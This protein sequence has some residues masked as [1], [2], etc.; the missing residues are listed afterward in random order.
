MT[1]ETAYMRNMISRSGEF[2]RIDRLPRKKGHPENWGPEKSVE[3]WNSKLRRQG[4]PASETL[5]GFQAQALQEFS[6]CKGLFASMA[7]GSGKGLLSLLLPSVFPQVENP[8]VLVPAKL[9]RQT[10]DEVIPRFKDVYKIRGDITVLSY[11]QISTAKNKDLLKTLRPGLVV[12]DECHLLKNFSAARTKR[13]FSYFD[14]NP[15]AMFVGLSGTI[16]RKSI[17]DYWRLIHAALKNG[18][19]PLPRGYPETQKWAKAL[20]EG[21][22]ERG[23]VHPGV[24]LDW[25]KENK[26]ADSPVNLARRAYGERLRDTFGVVAT[27]EGAIGTSLNIFELE[28]DNYSAAMVAHG[29]VLRTTWTMPNGE[30]ISDALSYYQGARQIACGFFYEWVWPN[31]EKNWDW[32][33]AR[34]GWKAA[35]RDVIRHNRHGLDSELLVASEIVRGKLVGPAADAYHDWLEVRD[36]YTVQTRPVWFTDWAVERAAA[37][38]EKTKRGIVWCEHS[39]FGEA[40]ANRLGVLYYGAGEKFN[41][42]LLKP[43]EDLLV[44]SLHAHGTGKNLQMYA[45]N[46]FVLP[47]AAGA[48]WEQ[49]LGRTHRPKQMADEVNAHV[50]LHTRALRSNF[51]QALQDAAYIEATTGQRQKLQYATVTLGDYL[52]LE[53]L[54][55]SL[56]GV[57]CAA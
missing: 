54:A 19:A 15:E 5:W 44:A 34:K 16:T 12:A 48:A 28:Q 2:V 3:F 40:L 37:W 20:D 57:K 33:E 31:G 25:S 32:L 39:A 7:V 46:L 47:P 1:T 30:E 27:T 45:E 24:I 51:T 41:R 53:D 10:L 42:R 36:Q 8:V 11:S 35:C 14:S 22:S 13:F 4:A 52:T 21:V 29:E 9:K 55:D 26:L 49:I 18:A 23:R 56:K 6:L 43:P 38:A 17:C 50:F